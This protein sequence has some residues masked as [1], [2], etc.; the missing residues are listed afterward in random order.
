[1]NKDLIMIIISVLFSLQSKAQNLSYG[2]HAGV[3][4]HS[5]NS[6]DQVR[7]YD[8]KTNLGFVAGSDLKY[9]LHN[10]I[11]FA[12]GFDIT[13]NAG[14]FSAFNDY[15]REQNGVDTEFPQIKTKELSVEVPI[16]IGYNLRLSDKFLFIPSIG[17]YS[18]YAFA[19]IKDK[20]ITNVGDGKTVSDEWKC[21]DGYVFGIH[22]IE[23][24]KHFD[25]GFKIK[26]ELIFASHYSL[27]AT[28]QKGFIEQNK[29][30]GIKDQN[31]RI[32]LGY[33]F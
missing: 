5:Y 32:C 8:Q 27:S 17:I 20:V 10:N 3:D 16:A 25:T 7:V 22:R 14:E 24:F 21:L 28:Y 11:I 30:F 15:Y 33:Y 31:M 18:R 4:V 9:T 23:G 26:A 12:S 6:V 1:M 2:V 13:L 19:S 29:Q